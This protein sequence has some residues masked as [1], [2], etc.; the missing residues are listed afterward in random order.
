M[1]MMTEV[2]CSKLIKGFMSGINRNAFLV[3]EKKN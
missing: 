1:D 3:R 2:E